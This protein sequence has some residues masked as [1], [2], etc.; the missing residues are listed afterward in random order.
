MQTMTYILMGVSL[1]VIM[2]NAYSKV[3]HGKWIGRRISTPILFFILFV[4]TIIS[5]V[6]QVPMTELKTIIESI[7]SK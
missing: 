6:K 4:L 3:K 5:A 7:A 2:G 1:F